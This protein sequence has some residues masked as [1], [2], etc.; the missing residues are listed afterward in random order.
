MF[1][2]NLK[3]IWQYY[4]FLCTLNTSF[5]AL[6]KRK[7]TLLWALTLRPVENQQ[8]PKELFDWPPLSTKSCSSERPRLRLPDLVLWIRRKTLSVSQLS[9]H[10]PLSDTLHETVTQNDRLAGGHGGRPK[11]SK[12]NHVYISPTHLLQHTG[13]LPNK[14]L[15]E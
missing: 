13:A 12:V 7:R 4:W 9:L 10:T 1:T 14:H 5:K 11:P 8:N 6:W 2:D 3:E 15:K